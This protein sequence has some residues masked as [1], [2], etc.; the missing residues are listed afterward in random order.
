MIEMDEITGKVAV[1]AIIAAHILCILM[2]TG[3]FK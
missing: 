2:M 1:I 3:I